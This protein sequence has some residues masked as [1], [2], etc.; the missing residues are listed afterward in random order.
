MVRS[1]PASARNARCIF[2][3]ILA[4]VLY[5]S[6][7]ASARPVSLTSSDAPGTDSRPSS[8]AAA[9]Q[10][11]QAGPLLNDTDGLVRRL[12]SYNGELAAARARVAQSRA[13][14]KQS[15]LYLNPSASVGFGGVNLGPKNPSNLGWNTSQNYSIGLQQTFEIGK[16][17]PRIESARLTAESAL[18]NYYSTL[19]ER[20][21]DARLALG[22]AV[23]LKAKLN[24]LEETAAAGRQVLQLEETRLRHGDI[25]GNDFDRLALDTSIHELEIPELRADLEETNATIRTLLGVEASLTSDDA[26]ILEVAAAVPANGDQW[27]AAIEA[28]P[29]IAALD[30][31]ANA[32][33]KDEELANNKSIPDPQIGITFLHDNLTEAGNQANTL[34]LTVGVE[35]PLFDRGQFASEKAREHASEMIQT[36]MAALGEARAQAS[37]LL[38]KKQLLDSMLQVI[39]ITNIPKSQ[40]ILDTTLAAYNRGQLSLT[41]LLLARR[42]HTELVL[43]AADLRFEAFALRNEVRRVLGLDAAAAKTTTNNR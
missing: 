43:R 12:E 16:R 31:A 13:D 17:A 35:I 4:P 30:F 25:S 19:G 11:F 41:D 21:A 38:Q 2:N 18:Q 1:A 34:A 20:V 37:S 7:C 40:N 8:G 14:H 24:L 10:A 27:E 26:G 39:Q 15:E 32:A 28:R 23:F 29:D 6:S 5:L 36:K 3:Y 42:T 33:R 22:R 9:I